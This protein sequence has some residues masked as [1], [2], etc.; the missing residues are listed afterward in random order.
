MIVAE[1]TEVD[2]QL[3]KVGTTD[4]LIRG[5]IDHLREF[6]LFTPFTDDSVAPE[7]AAAPGSKEYEALRIMSEKTHSARL[8]GSGPFLVQWKDEPDG[9]VHQCTWEVEENLTH[10]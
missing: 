1:P 6:K 3:R 10:C 2:Y 8:G 7:A 4:K 9:T 5:H